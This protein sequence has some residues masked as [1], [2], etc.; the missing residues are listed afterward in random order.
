MFMRFAIAIC[1]EDL[2]GVC[3]G[4]SFLGGMLKYF[5]GDKNSEEE[6]MLLK[7]VI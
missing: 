6:V 3:G 2:K 5:I 4:L 1:A 7:E